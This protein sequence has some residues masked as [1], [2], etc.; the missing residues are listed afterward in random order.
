MNLSLASLLLVSV[1]AN[2]SL[3]DRPNLN[4]YSGAELWDAADIIALVQIRA[5][6]YIEN[7]GFELLVIPLTT[8]KGYIDESTPIIAHY[9]LVNAPNQLGSNYLLFLSDT[10]R[11]KYSLIP[12]ARSAVKLLYVESDG[13]MEERLN[14]PNK[15]RANRDWYLLDGSLWMVECTEIYAY[16]IGKYCTAEYS[17]VEFVMNK[18]SGIKGE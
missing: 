10:G 1:L 8:F 14:D 16:P 5:G 2:D 7:E 6:S 18:A 13:D 12:E 4:K 9:P 15:A 17:I 11:G 3:A